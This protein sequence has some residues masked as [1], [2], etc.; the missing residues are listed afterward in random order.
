M[1][2]VRIFVSNSMKKVRF[3]RANYVVSDLERSLDFYC[4]VLGFKLVF[5]KV[6]D[7]D[8]YTYDVFE[9]DRSAG[10]RFAVL[11]TDT[12]DNVMALTE[13]TGFDLPSK[14]PP[15]TSAIVLDV[16]DIDDIIAEVKNRGL[17]CYREDHLVTQDGRK[18][19]E[20]GF[21]DYDGNLI[22]IYKINK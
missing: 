13:V 16:S 5:Q 11:A 21:L 17:T 2:I 1:F 9:I 19:R 20:Y 8:S 3:Q 18:G 6:S 15:F 12:Q 4:N 10:L 7:A 22:V 14:S